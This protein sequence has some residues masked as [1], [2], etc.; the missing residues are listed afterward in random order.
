MS[1]WKGGGDKRKNLR[2]SPFRWPRRGNEA[3]YAASLDAICPGLLRDSVLLL[4]LREEGH[5][6]HWNGCQCCW[7]G[8]R[9]HNGVGEEKGRAEPPCPVYPRKPYY[10]W[11]DAGPTFW[12]IVP[13]GQDEWCWLYVGCI[14]GCLL[15]ATIF[16]L[17]RL[18]PCWTTFNIVNQTVDVNF[19]KRVNNNLENLW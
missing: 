9:Y 1:S 18:E 15:Y 14:N 12:L 5:Q 13:S 3:I 19:A 16:A 6:Y 2:C 4:H 7:R 11:A 10:G 8:E 17:A